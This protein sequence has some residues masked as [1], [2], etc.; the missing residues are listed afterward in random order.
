M[1]KLISKKKVLLSIGIIMVC[2]SAAVVAGMRLYRNYH[3]KRQME[4][5]NRKGILLSFDDYNPDTWTE[6]MDLFDEYGVKVTFFVTLA[7]PTDFCAEAVSR[8]HEI[9]LHTAGHVKMT[10]IS[11]EEVYEQAIA[12]IEIF[13]AEGY[14]LTTFAYPYGLYSEELNEELLQYYETLR[15]AYHFQG[16]YKESLKKGFVEAYPLDNIYYESDEKFREKVVELLDVLSNCNDGTVASVYSHAIGAG[17]WCI[18]SA[19]LEILFEEAQKRDLVFY[20]YK[21]LQ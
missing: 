4:L 7:E 2:L 15:G 9:G 20:T 14:E 12:P 16:C 3:A 6:I 18:T 19:R 17:D 11:A 1:K 5:R 10:E 8:G 21:E 13:R